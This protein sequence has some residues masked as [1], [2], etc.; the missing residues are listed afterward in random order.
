M[1]KEVNEILKLSIIINLHR[2]RQH[3][4]DSLIAFLSQ[5]FYFSFQI[6]SLM[7]P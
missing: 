4:S 2:V 3:G 1:E 7:G 6:V 5:G